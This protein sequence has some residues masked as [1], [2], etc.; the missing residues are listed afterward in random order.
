MFEV[1]RAAKATRSNARAQIYLH[2]TGNGLDEHSGEPAARASLEKDIAAIEPELVP[3]T[4][5]ILRL[6]ADLK[7]VGTQRVP[8]MAGAAERCRA[9]GWSRCDA[10]ALGRMV[11]ELK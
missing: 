9:M 11:E 6:I 7:G 8:N 3:P 10:V 2:L 5:E 1:D 4:A